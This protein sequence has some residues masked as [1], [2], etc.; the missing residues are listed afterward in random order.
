[1]KRFD[2]SFTVVGSTKDERRI[3]E[4]NQGVKDPDQK[5]LKKRVVEETPKKEDT[6]KVPAKV[7]VTKQG[8]KKS[9]GGHMKMIARKR[10]RPQP[11]VNSDDEHRKCLKIITLEG[12]IDSEIMEKKSFISKLDKVSSPE[13]DYLVIHR[14]NGNFRAFNYLLEK[15]MIKSDYGVIN[16]I[17]RLS[18]GDCMKLVEMLDLGLEVERECS[19]ALDLI[20]V[21]NS[22]C[23]MVKSWLVQDQIVLDVADKTKLLMKMDSVSRSDQDLS[24]SDAQQV[25]RFNNGLHYHIQ[26]IISIQTS[27]T[28]DEAVRMELKVELTI[29]KGQSNSKFKNKPDLNQSSNQSGEKRQP[30]NSNEAE[31]NKSTYASTSSQA[32]KKPINQ[33]AWPVGNKCFKC[34]KTCHTSNQ[35]RAKAV[36]ITEQGEWLMLATPKK[37]EN[38]Q[39]HNILRT[40]CRINHDVVNVIIDG[41]SSENIISR[42]I[43]MEN[44]PPKLHDLLF[45]FKNTLP[46]ELTDGLPPLRDIQY[47]IDIILEASLLNLPHYRMSLTEH[48]ILQGM[49]FSKI[50]LRSGYH[51]LRIRPVMNG[52]CFKTKEGLYEW[53]L[54]PFGLSNAP[55][56]FMR[57]MN[58]VLKSFIGKFLVVYFDDILIYI[59]TEDEH[60]DHL[61]EVLKVLQEHQLFV[62][63][64]KCSFM[65]HKLLFLGFVVSAAETNASII[66]V[67]AVLSQ[68]GRPVA[69]FSEKLSEAQRKWT[70]YELEFYAIHKAGTKNKVA[71]ALSRR[72]TLLT[73][74]GT[75][76]IGFDCLKDL[77]VSDDDFSEIWKQNETGIPGGL[78]LVQDGFLFFK[79]RLC[80]PQGSLREHLIQELHGGGLGGHLSRDKT[81]K[82]VEE[83]YHWPQIKRDVHKFVKKCYICQTNKAIQADIRVKL[84]A[85]NA[86]H[87]EDRDKH[88]KTKIYAEDLVD[89]YPLDELLYPNKNLRSSPFQVG[90]NDEGDN[91]ET[92]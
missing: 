36:N 5:S 74:M 44:V 57:L 15:T 80:I 54:M 33:Y 30:L 61:R 26:A 58:E 27:W 66:G 59:N 88:H 28:L 13:G 87:K 92:N 79:D 71:N 18:L 85:S 12:T 37:S 69:F 83:R 24:E 50:D 72:A 45:E 3:K 4:M 7:D 82:L 22:P 49:V 21:L 65:T 16:K 41:G 89:Y 53:L 25:A 60:L 40:Q 38:T 6:T 51:Q 48:D 35:C 86:K 2:E 11:D 77:Y 1:M 76:V 47:Q 23:F 73:T 32:T 84:E 78:Y 17:G 10:K 67:G 91:L 90:E 75:E 9:K 81:I 56:T 63:L 55:S 64:K 68:E 14:A 39:W 19:V 70:T 31:K 46:E 62:N 34:Q 20:T 42:D 29:S 8:T 43:I 52:R